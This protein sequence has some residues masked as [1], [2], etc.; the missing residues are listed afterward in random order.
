VFA[1]WPTGD[2]ILAQEGALRFGCFL[3]VMLAV[4]GWERARPRRLP[5]TSRRHRWPV[6]L[7]L[8]AVDIV[9]VRL[10]LPAAMVSAALFAA[11]RGW[12]VLNHLVVPF[13]LAALVTIVLLD[14]GV[15]AQHMAM[16]KFTPLWRLHRVHHTDV[17]V[18]VTTGVRFHPFEI[19]LSMIYKSLLVVALG[20]PAIAALAFEILLNASSLFTH[21]NVRLPTA[22]DRV[23]R[24]VV[25]TPD[26]HRVHH[27]VLR[28]ETD[29]NYGFNLSIWD[30]LFG[31]YRAQP[32]AGHDGMIIGLPEFRQPSD[33]RLSRLLLQ[34]LLRRYISQ[35]RRTVSPRN[36]TCVRPT[37]GRLRWPQNSKTSVARH[38]GL[39]HFASKVD[40]SAS[41]AIYVD[42]HGKR[43]AFS[44]TARRSVQCTCQ[45]WKNRNAG[46]RS[47]DLRGSKK[48]LRKFCWFSK[49]AAADPAVTSWNW[50]TACSSA[51][52]K[53]TSSTPSCGPIDFSWTDLR[54]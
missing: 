51:A 50:L 12:G 25:V 44:E 33:Q 3:G 34:P 17:D 42:R 14:F 18:D 5:T 20:A 23:L 9:A 22:L 37:P 32:R 30:R 36:G 26:M 21:G 1:G 43:R 6:N 48:L 28:P 40:F 10:L 41:P 31:T 16:H 24:L 29:S 39:R 46:T 35:R 11:E 47:L 13:W 8:V 2:F 19:L 52:A 7:G 4:L 53:C 54:R 45:A 27:S 38:S 15:W 49:L